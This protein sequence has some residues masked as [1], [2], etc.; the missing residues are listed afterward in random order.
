MD[1]I[2]KI[3]DFIFDEENNF[4]GIA[5]HGYYNLPKD[6]F[7]KALNEYLSSGNNV[8]NEYD[9]IIWQ[10]WDEWDPHTQWQ[11]IWDEEDLLFWE[12]VLRKESFWSIDSIYNHDDLSLLKQRVDSEKNRIQYLKSHKKRRTDADTYTKNKKVR[13]SVFERDGKKCKACNS[14][15]DLTLDHIIPVSKDGTN[16]ISNLQILCRSCNSKKSNKHYEW[17]D[18]TT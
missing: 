16:R 2:Q 4:M 5:R 3:A 6:V 9:Q 8:L 17:M 13:G 11:Q 18:K 15:K 1:N 7:V 12:K 14:T 10:R